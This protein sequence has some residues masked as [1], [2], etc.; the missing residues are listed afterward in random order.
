MPTDTM[1]ALLAD[2]DWND[3]AAVAAASD[4]LLTALDSDRTTLRKLAERALD[5]PELLHLCEHYDILD[6][7]VLHNDP[8][9]WRLR[10]H[11]F[12]PGYFDR[13][14]N[15]RWTYSSRI[16]HGSY[17]HTLYGTDDQFGTGD[18]DV[19]ALRPRTVHRINRRLLHPAPHHNPLG[20]RAALH[21]LTN[22]PRLRSQGPIPRHRP[23]D[24]T[25]MVATRRD[26]RITRESRQQTDERCSRRRLPP[27]THRTPRAE[28][29][30]ACNHPVV[31]RPDLDHSRTS[32]ATLC[33]SLQQILALVPRL[34]WRQRW[35]D[36]L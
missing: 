9:G 11:V 34:V 16:L 24:R 2:V 10:L 19:A 7:I 26:H 4:K 12:L 29:T 6:K 21:H 15:H 17:T 32:I 20:D 5:N 14:H 3:L 22:R 18:I 13:P 23:H 36:G 33:L 27:T 8:S 1:R 25:S 28:R 35:N 30:N 31:E